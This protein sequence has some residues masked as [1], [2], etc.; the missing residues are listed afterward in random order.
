MS[1]YSFRTS[2]IPGVAVSDDRG[3]RVLYRLSH[4]HFAVAA[5]GG[6]MDISLA[7]SLRPWAHPAVLPFSAFQVGADS[8]Y[9]LPADCH[10]WGCRL[11]GPKLSDV[12]VF[13]LLKN[14]WPILAQK[15]KR[16]PAV[17]EM[18]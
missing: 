5:W 13:A 8:W 2:H 10:L 3:N 14:G 7:R 16:K 11:H 4:S 9:E 1:T 18:K 17:P 15:G 6:V 12:V